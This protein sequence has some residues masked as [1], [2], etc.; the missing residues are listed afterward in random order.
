[1]VGGLAMA[2][3]GVAVVHMVRH[4]LS[5]SDTPRQRAPWATVRVRLVPAAVAMTRLA[6]WVGGVV[7][8]AC[9]YGGW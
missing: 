7:A 3:G 6:G 8:V 1:M 4:G 9:R 2:A 5:P